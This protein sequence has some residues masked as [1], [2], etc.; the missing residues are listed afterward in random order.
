MTYKIWNKQE[1]INGVNAEEVLPT[2]NLLDNDEVF[3]VIDEYGTVRNIEIVR[4]IKGA[5]GFPVEYTAEETAQAYIDRVY[6][7]EQTFLYSNE[8][9]LADVMLK[10]EELTELIKNKL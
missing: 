3:L 8:P 1:S 6:N 5:Y 7:T 10:L 4:I 2:L 9:T